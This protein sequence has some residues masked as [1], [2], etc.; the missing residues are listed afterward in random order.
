MTGKRTWILGLAASLAAAITLLLLISTVTALR[1][2]GQIQ[3]A[4]L[5]QELTYQGYLVDPNNGQPVADGAYTMVFTIYDA[6]SGGNALWNQAFSSTNAVEVLDGQFTVHLG[7]PLAPIGASVFPG[8]PRWLG[9][10]VEGD[11]EMTPRTR[12][13]SVPYAL[14]AET[15]RAGGSTTGDMPSTLYK[16]VNPNP[17]GRA[18]VSEGDFHVQG[19]AHIQ[20]TLSWVTR[21][22]RLSIPAPAFRPSQ[23]SFTFTCNGPSLET[24]SEGNY[25]AP[26]DLPD[27]SR[28]TKM[29]F[30]YYDSN[31]Q[32]HV[33]AALMRNTVDTGFVTGLASVSSDTDPP[34]DGLDWRATEDFSHPE[35]DN[36]LH[37]YWLSLYFWNPYGDDVSDLKGK[38][39]IIEYEYTR[40]Y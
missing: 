26:V 18:L 21:T 19:D 36:R 24:G 39:V 9:M 20:G 40:P 6:A 22:G 10:S 37:T 11:P 12:F 16:F 14:R 35:V 15:L 38:A 5:P 1:P 2:D 25:Y 3:S 17:E 30:Y 27:H 28:L 32:A 23:S 13:T 4:P 8:G 7:G 31:S 34:P 29:Y 33:S